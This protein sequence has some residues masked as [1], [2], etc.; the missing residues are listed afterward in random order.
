LYYLCKRYKRIKISEKN[1]RKKKKKRK[2]KEK[3]S[4]RGNQSGPVRIKP[5][6]QLAFPRTIT[7]H[8]LFFH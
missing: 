5:T 2:E 6:A 8:L 3:V 1:K 7:L 4:D